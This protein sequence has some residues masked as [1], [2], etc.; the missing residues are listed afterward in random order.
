MELISEFHTLKL[1]S[2]SLDISVRTIKD[3][4]SFTLTKSKYE[5]NKC[6]LD[7]ISKALSKHGG[8]FDTDV[9]IDNEKANY[10][11]SKGSLQRL[12][13]GKWFND[14][15]VNAYVSLINDREKEFNLG[16]VFSFNTYFYT[17][18]EGMFQRGDYDYKKL[19]RVITRK[20]VNLKNYKMVMLPVNIQHYHWFLICADLVE[21]KFYVIDS[22][23]SSTDHSQYVNNF[24]KFLHDYLRANK[25]GRMKCEDN[26]EL[27]RTETP[28]NVPQQPN[29]YDCGLC[30]CLNMESLSRAP[31]V[32]E[33]QYQM[34]G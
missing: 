30:L 23:K 32:N 15:I 33:I 2:Q 21:D 6:Y 12:Q 25:G 5:I 28:K 7:L 14:E 1:H 26:L 20:K 29:G 3:P 11:I 10:R 8:H 34:N 31:K 4:D 16:S 19:E 17:M 13:P 18:M 9:V 24:K 27:W 22:M